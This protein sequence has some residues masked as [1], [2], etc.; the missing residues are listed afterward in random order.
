MKTADLANLPAALFAFR[1]ATV[2]AET[3]NATRGRNAKAAWLGMFNNSEVV[4]RDGD[5]FLVHA[6]AFAASGFNRAG[7]QVWQV[8][9]EPELWIVN[10][11]RVGVRVV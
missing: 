5:L 8:I 4:A 9:G 3:F 11:S 7:F 1:P 10:T 2:D 6:T